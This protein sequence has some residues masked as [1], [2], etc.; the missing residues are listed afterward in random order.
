[1][2]MAEDTIGRAGLYFDELNKI[3]VLDPDVA[4]QTNDLKDE[5]R[6]FSESKSNLVLT[7]LEN[8]LYIDDTI[9]TG[10]YFY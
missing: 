9:S 6:D 10:D 5:C 3:R 8:N 1:M 7:L 2:A 4:V